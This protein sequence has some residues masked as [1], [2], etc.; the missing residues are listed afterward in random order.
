MIETE[1]LDTGELDAWPPPPPAE[2]Y[3]RVGTASTCIAGDLAEAR[4]TF[5]RWKALH[6]TSFFEPELLA[7]VLRLCAGAEFGPDQP[8]PGFREVELSPQRAGQLVNL[9]LR[10]PELPRWLAQVTG[11]GALRSVEGRIAQT[12]DRPGDQLL[13]H[14]D[15]QPGTD[16]RRLAI[17]IH[18]STEAYTGGEFQIRYKT[19]E[20]LLQ[21]RHASV[22]SAMIFRVANTL[23]HRVLPLRSGGPRRVFAGWACEG[24]PQ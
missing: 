24:G 6:V 13:W 3:F 16:G 20:R 21:H 17:V 5:A 7:L 22:G 8:S 4:A 11:C 23:E 14:D 18:L 10:R 2:D 1:A 12:L 15:F 9:A 19:G